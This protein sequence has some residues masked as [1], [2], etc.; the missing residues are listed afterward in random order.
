MIFAPLSTAQVIAFASSMSENPG[1]PRFACT[2]I[3]CA[4]PPK[5]E[6]PSVLAPAASDATN[7]P[8]P[9]T[10][11][12]LGVRVTTFQI[13]GLFAAII[14]EERSAPVSITAIFTDEAAAVTHDGTRLA[15]VAVHCQ[16]G[17]DG[18]SRLARACVRGT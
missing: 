7:V 1:P 8:W 6:T 16:A 13:T 3:S 18:A 11:L 9:T 14:G 12:I 5:P 2:T 10:S 17:I 4:S 15:R